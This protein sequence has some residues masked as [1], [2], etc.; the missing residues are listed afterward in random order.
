MVRGYSFHNSFLGINKTA[1][2]LKL[3]NGKRSLETTPMVTDDG[4]PTIKSSEY[5]REYWVFQK[6]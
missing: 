1:M 5:W 4:T 2:V 6:P 3:N